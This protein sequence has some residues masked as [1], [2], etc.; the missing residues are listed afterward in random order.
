MVLCS[1]SCCCWPAPNTVQKLSRERVSR[2]T[3]CQCTA[4]PPLQR[5]PVVIQG[6][7]RGTWRSLSPHE[8]E[9]T[10]EDRE[11][12][13]QHCVQGFHDNKDEMLPPTRTTEDRTRRRACGVWVCTGHICSDYKVAWSGVWLKTHL[14]LWSCHHVL[15]LLFVTP[16][17]HNTEETVW[18]TKRRVKK[19]FPFIW[20][21]I[22]AWI[23]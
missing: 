20:N 13:L 8:R 7:C 15:P 1:L 12:T 18:Q 22:W 17:T 3:W 2:G 9:D 16:H 5:L 4:A 6:N 21:F 19:C 23:Q 11:S 14:C 10:L